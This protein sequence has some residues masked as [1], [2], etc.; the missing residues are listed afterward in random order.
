MHFSS[1][2]RYLLFQIQYLN[3][4][5]ALEQMRMTAETNG[6]KGPIVMVV[7]PMDVGKSTLCRILLN[8]SVRSGH[9]PIYVDVDVGQG[10]I[11]IPGTIGSLLIERPAAAEEGFSQLAPFVF[12]FGNKSPDDNNELYKILTSKLA[13][14]TM[15]R[16]QVD[17]RG[18][19]L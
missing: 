8:Y 18:E 6:T 16:L 14:V 10:N 7:G 13:D 1:S 17:K 11:S 15:E 2:T 4:H 19:K 12:H 5:A 3:T 9:R